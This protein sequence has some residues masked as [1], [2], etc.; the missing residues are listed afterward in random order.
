MAMKAMRRQAWLEHSG[1][2][3]PDLLRAPNPLHDQKIDKDAV[4]YL[5]GTFISCQH[6]ANSHFFRFF[7]TFGLMHQNV[8]T[9]GGGGGGYVYIPF[10]ICEKR[11]FQKCMGWGGGVGGHSFAHRAVNGRTHR[12]HAML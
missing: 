3:T 10:E 7:S 6:G 5:S 12:A 11:P 8:I 2:P 9:C 4:E 1:G